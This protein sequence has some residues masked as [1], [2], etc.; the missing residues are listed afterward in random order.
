VDADR[1]RMRSGRALD[2]LILAIR[3]LPAVLLIWLVA[4]IR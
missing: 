4:E 2:T 1:A 3:L